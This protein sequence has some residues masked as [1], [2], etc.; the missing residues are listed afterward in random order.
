MAT[1]KDRKRK[2]RKKGAPDNPAQSRKIIEAAQKLGLDDGGE[3]FNRALNTLVPK[4]PKGKD[5]DGNN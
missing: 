1:G 2:R 5:K 3:A 4:K